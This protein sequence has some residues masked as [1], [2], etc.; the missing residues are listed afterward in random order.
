MNEWLAD[1]LV[2]TSLLMALVLL[3]RDPVR[4]QF[5]PAAAYGLWLI[6]ALRLLMPPLTETVE[7][8]DCRSRFLFRPVI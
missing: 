6:P 1:T 4:R 3:V 5:G 7:R 2:A 8:I